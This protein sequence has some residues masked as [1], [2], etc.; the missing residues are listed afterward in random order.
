LKELVTVHLTMEF[1]R[2]SQGQFEG[3]VEADDHSPMEFSGTL[4][5]L[6]VL[7]DLTPE[8]DAAAGAASDGSDGVK[9]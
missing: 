3:T 7:Q 4:E 8:G 6:K 2:N 5:L 9:A 1:V